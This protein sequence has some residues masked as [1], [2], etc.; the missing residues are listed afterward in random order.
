M[1]KLQ[2][3]VS[4]YYCGF[5]CS[6]AHS[7]FSALTFSLLFSCFIFSQNKAICRANI[8]VFAA[9]LR[10]LGPLH[11]QR[12]L[13]RAGSVSGRGLGHR[14]A[15]LARLHRAGGRRGSPKRKTREVRDCGVKIEKS[16]IIVSVFIAANL[17]RTEVNF[18]SVMQCVEQKRKKPEINSRFSPAF[19]RHA[20]VLCFPLVEHQPSDHLLIPLPLSP[21]RRFLQLAGTIRHAGGVQ[22]RARQRGRR[23]RRQGARLPLPRLQQGGLLADAAGC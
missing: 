9:W 15:G 10:R 22:R 3:T 2:V 7:R 18:R 5:S 14:R 20:Q 16:V 21:S 1:I 4:K 19:V 12:A 6:L 17:I 8:C 11:V 23:A 13:P